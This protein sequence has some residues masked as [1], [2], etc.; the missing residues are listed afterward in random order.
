MGRMLI[1]VLALV[2][3]CCLGNTHA[4]Q[5]RHNYGIEVANGRVV[6][7]TKNLLSFP[8]DPET[9]CKVEVVQNEPMYQKVGSFTP[10]TFDCDYLPNSVRYEHNG[11]PF[12]HEDVVKLRTY[13][14]MP[15]E[16]VQ[17]TVLV[18]ITIL[19]SRCDIIQINEVP[20]RVERTTSVS[21][22][23]NRDVMEFHYDRDFDT[24][25]EVQIMYE[26]LYD[27][28]AHGELVKTANS[29]DEHELTSPQYIRTGTIVSRCDDF[30]L[31]GVRYKH[32]SS[33]TPDVDYIPIHVIVTDRR[34]GSV[35]TQEKHYL[36]VII[37]YAFPNQPP[38][39]S[40]TNMYILEVDQF[41][42]TN[43]LPMTVSAMDGET[44]NERLIF[45][46]TK[47]PADGFITHLND[48]SKQIDSFLQE[49]LQS[50]QIAYQPPNISYPER[51][52]FVVE[53]VV[54]DSYY[55]QSL[56]IKALFS[57]RV[58]RTNAP[59][60]SWNMG[61]SM[62][63]GQSRP[64]TH[65]SFQIVDRDN[66][67]QVRFMLAGGLQHGRLYINNRPGFTFNWRD[68]E[69]NVVVYRHDDTDTRKDKIVFRITDG[70]HSTRFKLPITI[71]PKDDA[72]PYLI[73]NIV[74][75]VREGQTILIHRFMLEAHDADSSA[76][77]IKFN[78]T[79]LPSAG[80]IQKRRK[81]ERAGWFVD[82]FQ[83]SDLYQGLIYYKHLGNEL[84][85]DSFEFTLIDSC[86]PV[87]N[88]S[89]VHKVV[90]RITPV[91][92][93]PPQ[94]ADGNTL[95]L[96]LNET[97]V[98][99]LTRRELHY[100]DMEDE[101]T[102]V[103]FTIDIGCRVIGKNDEM[104]AGRLVF[105][106]DMV[107][108]MKDPS[109][110]TLRTFTQSA[111]D[112]Q[113]V[114][115]M[116][117][118]SDIGLH[119]VDIEFI[120]TVSDDHNRQVRGVNFAITLLPVDNQAPSI[121]GTSLYLNEG[122][123]E[124]IS[125]DLIQIDDED[126]LRE[127]I[128]L[129]LTKVPSAGTI[130]RDGVA[131]VENDT[132]LC[133]D[134]EQ[135]RMVYTH[136]GSENHLDQFELT[137]SDGKQTSSTL[138]KVQ[139]EPVDDLSPSIH[140]SNTTLS[141][142]EGGSVLIDSE[143]L[144]A[145][146]EDT[147]DDNLI[148]EVLSFPSH[149]NIVINGKTVTTF[150]QQ[151]IINKKVFYIHDKSEVGQSVMH[152]VAT[153][154]VTDRRGQP[155]EDDNS[156]VKTKDL[157]FDIYPINSRPPR[158]ALGNEVFR[159]NEGEFKTLSQNFL[160]ADD[161]DTPSLNLSFIITE[162][163]TFG[164]LE[165]V[166]PRP[167]YEKIIGKRTT[168]FNYSQLLDGNIRYVQSIHDGIEPTSD[169][170]SIQATDGHYFSQQVPFL[171]SITP[172]N[173]EEPV[174]RVENITCSEGNMSPMTLIVDDMD[175]PHDNVMVVVSKPPSHGMVVDEMEMLAR[176]RRSDD[177]LREES[178]H[179]EMHEM[180]EFSME[181]LAHHNVMPTYMHD[182]SE[183]T[184]D[185]IELKVTDGIHI[186][187]T[188]LMVNIIQVNDE[189]PIVVRNEGIR[190]EIGSTKIIS[191]VSLQTTDAD[192][193]SSEL[194][195]E[196]HSIPRR[197]D[198]QIKRGNV[199]DS[200]EYAHT[201]T[202]EDVEM[203]R[204]RYQHS[205]VL[206]SKAQ[207]SF[208]FSVTDGEFTTHRIRFNI[209][210]EHTKKNAVHIITHPLHVNEGGQGFVTSNILLASDGAHRPEEIT[211]DVIGLPLYGQIEYVNFPQIPIEMFSQLDVLARNVKYVHTSKVDSPV[212]SFHI[213]AS[214]GIKTKEVDVTVLITSVD[215]ELPRVSIH[216]DVTSS[217]IN[218]GQSNLMMYSG[219]TVTITNMIINITD[220]DT[221]DDNV[222]LNIVDHP[223]HGS[224]TCDG[225]FIG[226][227]TVISLNDLK[228]GVFAYQHNG[229]GASIDRFTFTVSDG[230]HAGYIYQGH[231]TL[232][233]L[234]FNLRIERLD[235]SS[236]YIAV[237]VE[238]TT[239]QAL[240]TGKS[241]DYGIYLD[242]SVLRAEDS[243]TSRN[244]DLLFSILTPPSYG[245]LRLVG[246]E[247]YDDISIM[248]FTQADLDHRNI[249]YVI[250]SNLR[251]TNDN[252][253]FTVQDAWSNMLFGNKFSMSW[254]RLEM[255]EKK[256]KICEEVGTI[257]ISL[258]RMGNLSQ[259]S[260]I[261]VFVKPGSA[262]PELDYNPSSAL[263][264]QFDPGSAQQTWGVTINT[265]EIEERSEKFLVKLHAPVNTVL[266][267]EKHK[268]L[269][270]IKDHSHPTC[271]GRILRKK[272][273]NK[274]SRKKKSKTKKSKKK[275]RKKKHKNVASDG[276][277]STNAV[278]TV[279][280][281]KIGNG[282][283]VS[284]ASFFRNE[285]HRIWRYHGILPVTVDETEEHSI[286]LPSNI[287][288]PTESSNLKELHL[289]D[290]SQANDDPAVSKVS[291]FKTRINVQNS[292][293]S[294]VITVRGNS[295]T[296]TP[297]SS[298]S[299]LCVL[300]SRG[301]L[302]Y[303]TER[304]AL[305]QC[306]GAEWIPWVPN[307]KPKV[308]TVTSQVETCEDGWMAFQNKC[309][310][311]SDVQ[312][313]SW[314][315][316]QRLC[317][318]THAAN[319][320]SIHNRKQLNWL[321]KLSRKNS[322]YLG[323]N[324]KLNPRNWEWIDGNNVVFTNWK[325]GFPHHGGGSCSIVARKRWINH[326]CSSTPSHQTKYICVR[327]P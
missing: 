22:P 281:G 327:N 56:P 67:Y 100:I 27:F 62:L 166:T 26:G 208:R 123:T 199:W 317:R 177:V 287:N 173:D 245:I 50:L 18:H 256:I 197:G 42:L 90:I 148:F 286:S 113:K 316:A 268:T 156:V 143:F 59:R 120:F 144:S 107:M 74:F 29:T 39:P 220:D 146:D 241:P 285:T 5:I 3:N 77:Y 134:I 312:D 110:P 36:P 219:S 310:Y 233:A 280:Y 217:N 301:R 163:P 102:D 258:H 242:S 137:V 47:P 266:S 7:M 57:V 1:F 264:V 14:L 263:Q 147:T 320:V 274:K 124:N 229:D 95:S 82:K 211:F 159:C 142:H 135:F 158:I 140:G 121:Q 176:V 206:G 76:D 257:Q 226:Q 279:R 213:L 44:N 306:N 195:Y 87:P 155:S 94:P 270:I 194:V 93:L 111:V 299:K 292:N 60:V 305:F 198:L 196:L 323:L 315:A 291:L 81:W 172:M 131:M 34:S 247:I 63:E 80:E 73:N 214:N 130:F 65:N 252:F 167:G 308:S 222:R 48:E 85:E 192:T 164:Y 300:S 262:R 283:T 115:Y 98:V 251:V 25:C 175:I 11:S 188:K 23:I 201:F 97:D 86:V 136:D 205:S 55:L 207:D 250:S 79:K 28:P 186:Q 149:G 272:K 17:E 203:N 249:V 75:N 104:N 112:H 54:F 253:T 58:A 314:N 33:P 244:E 24:I 234:S 35:L 127:N 228:R 40:F 38:K 2:V 298:I 297:S 61:L 278:R 236:P 221:A 157:L 30:L 10:E 204:I 128:I 103:T 185:Q 88:I 122:G 209:N 193:E 43:I 83:Q 302:Y 119:P 243:A 232:E 275:K 132:F 151:D 161:I 125:P 212:D 141:V 240:G 70:F 295:Q 150:L 179:D 260:F 108:L 116:P 49:D 276:P 165:D 248:Q 46:I 202:E 51:H 326:S 31:L 322:F 318:E 254:S 324:G 168:R 69:N 224:L 180:N 184:F 71:L 68:I 289:I 96:T 190:L 319:L 89:P 181:Q 152:D 72:P 92:D 64:L 267:R 183:S 13:I 174:F 19:N 53:F 290:E 284:P 303:D 216:T 325:N 269:I 45:N 313:I 117:P 169:Q 37:S 259:S 139:M 304:S 118:M 189:R 239:I 235:E 41:V 170:F 126:T 91:D 218:A 9:P 16:T 145:T 52:S 191:S 84:F 246:Q 200:L 101:E 288:Q 153:V 273:K 78:I 271:S 12:L 321:W 227:S 154:M 21:N 238:P 66:L 187:K 162:N 296:D 114:A 15:N 309:Y 20:L 210:I 225:N 106:D 99:H 311:V 293:E 294:A 8:S 307:S 160:M 133:Q 231:R 6:Y 237:N 277:S 129:V 4:Q 182:G 171:V 255:E 105:T 265:D 230:V 215:E 261:S 32:G 223:E 178:H 138:M 109:V 282:I